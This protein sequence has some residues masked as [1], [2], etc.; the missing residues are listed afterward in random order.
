[1][2][3]HVVYRACIVLLLLKVACH[4]Y[5]MTMNR[6]VPLVWHLSQLAVTYGLLCK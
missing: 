2:M 1:M 4:T 5:F 3:H 6:S